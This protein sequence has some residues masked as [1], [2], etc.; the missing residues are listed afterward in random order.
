MQPERHQ[1]LVEV[2]QIVFEGAGYRF[3]F[4]E[5]GVLLLVEELQTLLLSLLPIHAEID[6]FRDFRVDAANPIESLLVQAPMLQHLDAFAG[7]SKAHI[8]HR[9][10]FVALEGAWYRY[11][12]AK[13]E[14]TSLVATKLVNLCV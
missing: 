4:G 1:R 9:V 5:V 11:G 3:G 2:S 12:L 8:V 10:L 13:K 14:F 7:E 6:E